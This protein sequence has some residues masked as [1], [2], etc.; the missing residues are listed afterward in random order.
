MKPSHRLRKRPRPSIDTYHW[1]KVISTVPTIEIQTMR[2]RVTPSSPKMNTH[3]WGHRKHVPMDGC[4]RCKISPLIW[5]IPWPATQVAPQHLCQANINH[6]LALTR[7]SPKTAYKILNIPIDRSNGPR[8]ISL[9]L[10]INV[11]LLISLVLDIVHSFRSLELSFIINYYYYHSNKQIYVSKYTC[12]L[13]KST[14]NT[15]RVLYRNVAITL[16]LVHRQLNEAR[17]LV[18]TD[19]CETYK[20]SCTQTRRI[21]ATT[22]ANDNRVHGYACDWLYTTLTQ[23]KMKSG[24]QR[25]QQQQTE[26]TPN[27]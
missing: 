12:Q 25:R 21:P 17:I 6:C 27:I 15:L 11:L 8:K 3:C 24:R 22:T 1:R 9:S 10:S 23:C 19:S 4:R 26:R 16:S 2:T 20:C 7:N 5:A 13:L 14:R 18:P